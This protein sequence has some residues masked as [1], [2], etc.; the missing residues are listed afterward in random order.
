[1]DDFK[2]KLES[3]KR[4][5]IASVYGLAN[6][7]MEL[8]P[9]KF[10]EAILY[11]LS[12]ESGIKEFNDTSLRERLLECVF[13]SIFDKIGQDNEDNKEQD[14][15]K[16]EIYL[17]L[18][19]SVCLATYDQEKGFVV[20]GPKKALK[21]DFSSITEEVELLPDNLKQKFIAKLIQEVKDLKIDELN[22]ELIIGEDGKPCNETESEILHYIP[23]EGSITSFSKKDLPYLR[24]PELIYE[25]YGLE[26]PKEQQEGMTKSHA[27]KLE[28]Q[29]DAAEQSSGKGA[30]S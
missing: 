8:Q 5:H 19:L 30:R 2:K 3:Y 14:L 27:E 23:K 28:K 21:I 20:G 9:E 7:I 24:N 22:D 18:G 16:L 25:R 13:Y 12:D 1:M 4:Y 6:D 17:D 10:K 26:K 11:I 29:R 15:K